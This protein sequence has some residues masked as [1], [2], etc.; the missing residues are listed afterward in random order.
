MCVSACLLSWA[1]PEGRVAGRGTGAGYLLLLGSVTV[2][3]VAGDAFTFL[4]AWESLTVAFYVLT[5]SAGRIDGAT[6]RA[7]WATLGMG[8]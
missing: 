8:K 7:S 2:V 3:F 4:F 1:R 5:G 6:A